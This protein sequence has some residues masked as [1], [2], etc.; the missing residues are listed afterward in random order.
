MRKLSVAGFSAFLGGKSVGLRLLLFAVTRERS[1]ATLPPL[2]GRKLVKLTSHIW[3]RRPQVP[4]LHASLPPAPV[5]KA[6]VAGLY[7]GD[8]VN[9]VHQLNSQRWEN[10]R[11]LF[12]SGLV[13]GE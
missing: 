12:I 10:R 1:A 6:A 2:S 4:K 9:Q 13:G 7:A 5:V 8:P 3:K 11:S